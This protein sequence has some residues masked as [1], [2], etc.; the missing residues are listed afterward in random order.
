MSKKIDL[1]GDYFNMSENKVLAKVNGKEIKQSD[2]DFLLQGLGPQRA[3]QFQ[4][5]EG[6]KQLI[7]ELIH[8]ELFYIDAIDS[9]VNE[10]EEFVAELESAK[11][12]LL[13]QYAIRKLLQ[14][15]KVET[16]EVAKYYEENKDKFKTEESVQASHILVETK[17]QAD[18]IVKEI[19]EGLDFAEAAGKYSKCPS[20]GNGGDLGE[21]TKGKMVPEF[22]EV[23]FDLPVGEISEPFS[24]QFGFHIVKV[25]NKVEGA[26][27]SLEDS[28]AEIARM[29]LMKKQNDAYVEKTSALKEKNSVE[30]L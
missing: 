22:E 15:V 28:K 18:D 27:K 10:E 9:N 8:Q 25:T 3:M 24:T 19:N 23:A 12:N 21:F 7:D 16:E 13:K 5:E 26:Q 2:L 30:V 29:L 4:S 14:S 20:K 1:K 17:E 11:V 6:R